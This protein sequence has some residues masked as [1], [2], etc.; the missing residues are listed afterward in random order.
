MHGAREVTR[1]VA[2]TVLSAFLLML[3]VSLGSVAPTP[4]TAVT[5]SPERAHYSTS[6]GAFDPS[7]SVAIPI[8][9]LQQAHRADSPTPALLNGLAGTARLPEFTASSAV[10]DARPHSTARVTRVGRAPPA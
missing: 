3:C 5:T 4:A 7:S 6:D 2:L 10:P 1:A 9:R 8:S